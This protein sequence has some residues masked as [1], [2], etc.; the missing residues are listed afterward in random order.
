MRDSKSHLSPHAAWAGALV[1]LL[2]SRPLRVPEVNY[3]TREGVRFG[4]EVKSEMKR[5]ITEMKIVE[6]Q[7]RGEVARA[8]R[9][10]GRGEQTAG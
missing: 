4:D 9:R 8:D 1:C 5:R 2:T 6:G 3:Q 10:T 7:R